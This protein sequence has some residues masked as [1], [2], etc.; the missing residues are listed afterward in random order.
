MNSEKIKN[1]SFSDLLT[2]L[3]Q[4]LEGKSYTQLTLDN[5]RKTLKKIEPYMISQGIHNYLPE[6]GVRYYKDYFVD[7]ELGS[8]RQKAMITAIQRLNNFY[9]GTEYIIQQKQEIKL[10]TNEYEHVLDL[11]T[12]HCT[13]VGNKPITLKSK[14]RFL[15]CFLKDCVSLMCSDFHSLNPPYVTKACLMVEN[16]DGWAVIRDFLKFLSTSGI[17]ETDFSTLVPH[18]RKP[19]NIPVTYNEVEIFQFE[20]VIDRTSDIGKRDYA[21]LI[22]ATRLGMRSGDIVKLSLD[23]LDFEHNKIDF[24]QQ[25]TGEVL[26]LPM[27][28]EVKTALVDYIN[29]ARP[30]AIGNNVF[31]RHKAP[32][33]E[34]TTSV[35]RFETT[36]Y[37]KMAGIDIS[38]KKHGPHTFRSSL[39]SSMVNDDV[40]FDV[41][42]KIL[43]HADPDAIKHY[44]KLDIE[45]L[46]KFAIEV[47]KPSGLFKT[48]L[49][50]GDQS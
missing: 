44:A 20:E 46:R 31:L 4:Y 25:K 9:S 18:Y 45:K 16:K 17:I 19:I 1:L 13:E 33:Q 14:R 3:L 22:L 6:V 35:L 50:G 23:E 15:Q 39:A 28:L 41:V 37:F 43:G 42:R 38:G 29:N 27:L 47:P 2:T 26:Q 32:Y 12:L 30:K 24:I 34:I 21:M 8:S 40:P 11:F 10:L 36:R 49:D 48:F 5:Y 7:H